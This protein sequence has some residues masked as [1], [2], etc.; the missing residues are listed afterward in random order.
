MPKKI[1]QDIIVNRKSIRLVKKDG[2]FP[3][4]VRKENREN[5]S[6]NTVQEDNSVKFTAREKKE[7]FNIEV[8]EPVKISNNSH[9]FL[10]ILSIISVG[11]LIFLIS[12]SFS[13]A[14]ITIT[15]KSE[16]II[17]DD[18]IT[19]TSKPT[20]GT[21]NFEVMTVQKNSSKSLDTDGE[22]SVERKAVGKVILYNSYST[23]NQRLITNTRLESANQLT[24]RIRSSADIPGYKIVAGKKIPGSIEVEI[25][26]DEAGDKYNMKL[27]DLKGDFKVPGF[28]GS[29]KYDGF[30]ARLSVDT[31]GGLVGKVKKV[32]EEK[33]A[34]ETDILKKSL[35]DDL[36]KELYQKK[37]DQYEIFKDNYYI[38]YKQLNDTE[39]NS[40]KYLLTEEGT[41]N[42]IMFKKENLAPFIAKLKID[43]YTGDSVEILWADDI[44]VTTSNTSAEP[45]L[46]NSLKFKFVGSARIAWVYSYT[47]IIQSIL[48]QNK[49]IINDLTNDK[50]KSS[51][52]SISAVIRPQW[53]NTFPEKESRIKI[54]DLVRNREIIN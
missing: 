36:I 2:A 42:A 52:S 16:E 14:N 30:Y 5:I 41:I 33:L 44:S 37:P 23:T 50:F 17:L 51:I 10:W 39:S 11:A 35:K 28:K 25:I 43:K 24:Y 46:E 47:D 31:T 38:S 40:N 45:W 34:A 21:L 27:S 12:G 20:E 15:P 49:S 26:A 1:I 9:I 53:K 54:F 13:T 29:P 8:P 4:S 19:A 32:S 22:E 6:K 3:S 7:D 18:T 48:G